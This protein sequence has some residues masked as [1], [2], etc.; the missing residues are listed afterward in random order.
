MPGCCALGGSFGCCGCCCC[1]AD[2]RLRLRPDIKINNKNLR[3]DSSLADRVFAARLVRRYRSAAQAKR[4]CKW[5]ASRKSHIPKRLPL[6]H[7]SGFRR[8][9]PEPAILRCGLCRRKC[10]GKNSDTRGQE[11]VKKSVLGKR[12]ADTSKKF[13]I[14]YPTNDLWHLTIHFRSPA[15]NGKSHVPVPSFPKIVRLPCRF[16]PHATTIG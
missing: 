5:F 14:R 7:G 1:A 4:G 10:L 2:S 16:S 13:A 8:N 12:R 11:A 3:M 9:F 15:K 6:V